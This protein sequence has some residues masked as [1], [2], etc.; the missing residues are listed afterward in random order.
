MPL[1]KDEGGIYN[2]YVSLLEA[3]Q[4]TAMQNTMDP[5][6]FSQFEDKLLRAKYRLF[7]DYPFFGI[8][9][10]KLKTIPTD[11][12]PTMAVDDFSNIYIN[13]DFVINQ[14]SDNEV[15]GVLAHEVMHIATLTFFRQRSRDMK[16]WNIATDYIMN[17]DLLDMNISLPSLGLI[18]EGGPGSWKVNI[19][20]TGM[21][22]D[23][24]DMTA[25]ELYDEFNKVKQTMQKE[26][27]QLGLK[28]EEL[29]KHLT[30]E[31]AD[32]IESI[33]VPSDNPSYKP[34]NGDGQGQG[35]TQNQ[36]QS[37]AKNKV[38]DAL[39]TAEK[40]RGDSPGIPRS[41]NKR[42]LQPKTDYK[43]LLKDFI[44][45][46][47]RRFYDFG[48]PNRRALSSGYYAPRVRKQTSDLD[49]VVAI[50]TSGSISEDLMNVFVNEIYKILISFQN[51]KLTLLLWSDSVYF[52]TSADTKKDTPDVIRNNL[53]KL[54]FSS[55]GTSFGSI[56]KYLDKKYPGQKFNG[57]VVF[58]DGYIEDNPQ[59]PNVQK[60][61][62]LINEP[63]GTDDILKR[64]G[65][66]YFIEVERT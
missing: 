11:S 39:Q 41:F 4:Q 32:G 58:T 10:T 14:L 23:I 53:F 9:L 51:V 48:R 63:G 27:E 43:K 37:E 46:A 22:I 25:E 3:L 44:S 8:L 36:K 33:D 7:R 56:K 6:M 55:G 50:D 62:F 20:D 17:R 45:G 29:D 16:L 59:M 54:P 26:I 35:K 60:K 64:F 13:P 18:P 47:S 19:M 65:P 2:R 49:I 30:P 38:Q 66:T 52:E 42:L 57:L 12:I 5:A 1:N 28:Q 24:T 61:L 34:E 31:E 15:L 40:T 21:K